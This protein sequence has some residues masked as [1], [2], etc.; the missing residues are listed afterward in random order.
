MSD[1]TLRVMTFNL[2]VDTH[3]DGDNR[4]DMRKELALDVIRTFDP[5]IL[6][7]QEPRERQALYLKEQMPG[8]LHV[9]TGRDGAAG[10]QNAVFLRRDRFE[11][12]DSGSSWISETPEAVG[13]MGWDAAYSRLATW[14]WLRDK[15]NQRKLLFMNTHL[16]NKGEIARLEGAKMVRRWLTEQAAG[17][18]VIFTADLNCEDGTPPVNVLLADEPGLKL[19]DA[20]RTVQPQVQPDDG[21]LH[22]FVGK[23]TGPRIDYILHT[24][25]LRT[26]DA[27][28]VRTSRDGRYPSDHFPLAATLQWVD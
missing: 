5:D 1:L 14:M 10:E 9:G 27:A 15:R 28:I 16:D 2:R 24:P 25:H 17:G 11:L 12:L 7:T 21:T 4:W 23:T 19:S 8:Y 20:Y 26:V 3:V 18:P 13:S 22:H 6:G